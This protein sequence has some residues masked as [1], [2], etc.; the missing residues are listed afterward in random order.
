MW[1]EAKKASNKAKKAA[2]PN[3]QSGVHYSSPNQIRNVAMRLEFDETGDVT[4]ETAEEKTSE[5]IGQTVG[6][7][8][9]TT[10]LHNHKPVVKASTAHSIPTQANS[11]F[12]D[13]W[14]VNAVVG[15]YTNPHSF[16]PGDTAALQNYGYKY[17]DHD[18]PWSQAQKSAWYNFS[19]SGSQNVNTFFRTGDVGLY[20]D[21]ENAKKR[22]KG[23]VDAFKSDNV[24]PLED[25]TIVTRGTNGGWE[26]GIGSDA[27][28]FDQLQGMVGKVVR[29]KCPVSTSLRGRPAFGGAHRVTYK[30]PPGFRGLG[31]YGKSAHGHE[32]EMILPPGMA[33]RILEVKKG[34]ESYQKE[35][36][37]EVVDVKLPE[38]D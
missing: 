17:T 22:A 2:G 12:P 16:K 36:L 6:Q 35:I 24:K 26:F 1:A 9:K 8:K 13:H 29:N 15:S 18:K 32:N 28:S 27:V 30:L 37:V 4:W 11:K 19:G 14:D 21:I 34:D 3:A 10:E 33:Y 31:I 38:I 20:G 25:W 5:T 7:I 23:I